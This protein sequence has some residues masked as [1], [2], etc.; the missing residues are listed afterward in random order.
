M[1]SK[2][3]DVKDDNAILFGLVDT[4]IGQQFMCLDCCDDLSP[5][6]DQFR[7]TKGEIVEHGLEPMCDR[8]GQQFDREYV[9]GIVPTYTLPQTDARSYEEA[10]EEEMLFQHLDH[11]AENKERERMDF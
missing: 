2:L 8:C 1:Q 7:L 5:N 3:W 11:V 6:G 10:W 9:C 4:V